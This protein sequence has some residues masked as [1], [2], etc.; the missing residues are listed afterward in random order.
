MK[1]S[2]SS[3]IS[4]RRSAS[5]GT[6]TGTTERRWN[7]SSRKPPS[8]MARGKIARGRGNHPHIDM[9]AGGPVHTRKI[10]V[11]QHA[12]DFRLGVARHVGHFVD[13]ER[14]A[15]RLL[16]RAGF[17]RTPVPRLDPKKLGLHGLG[18]DGRR[19][20][21]HKR[22]R[23]ARGS[24][25]DRAGRK[26]LADARRA[27]DQN[28]RIGRRDALDQSGAIG[29][30]GRVAD[31]RVGAAERGCEFGDFA[32]QARGLQRPFR[33]Q[34]Q[35]VGLEGLLDEVIGADGLIAVTA[36]SILP[37]PEIITMG[38]S[39]CWRLDDLREI[40]ARR[41]S[42][43][44]S[45]CRERSGAAGAPRWRPAPRRNFAPCAP[46]W[47]SSSRMPDTSSR[48]SASSSTIRISLAM[49]NLR[50]QFSCWPARMHRLRRLLRRAPVTGK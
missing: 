45:R 12:Q 5:E 40:A 18:G 16:E 48:M 15:M 13:I 21:D 34:H 7:R 46:R 23:R 8:A 50:L 22:A 4:S 33:D 1:K 24:L 42:S 29:Q 36:V 28:A 41:A 27:G 9:D 25:M 19:I 17:A 30:G 2:I 14:A 3:G 32:A 44:A 38:R 47:P 37:W 20:D 26:F 31:Q 49:L 6:R 43:P 35:P 11:D 39:G 10:L